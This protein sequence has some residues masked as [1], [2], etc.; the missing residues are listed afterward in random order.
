[1]KVLLAF[2]TIYMIV[3]N[4]LPCA[5]APQEILSKPQ[6][7][8]VQQDEGHAD[9]DGCSPF[10]QCHCC[11][12]HT[13]DVA[14]NDYVLAQPL[15]SKKVIGYQDGASRDYSSRILQPPRFFN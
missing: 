13:L 6:A 9:L 2:F 5:D 8:S 7:V 4:T 10:C 11:H 3:L 14:A 12:F 15:I 1:M